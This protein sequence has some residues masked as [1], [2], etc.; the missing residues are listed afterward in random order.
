MS[1]RV[2]LAVASSA[3][4][5]AFP[6]TGT[7]ATREGLVAFEANWSIHLV[8]PD[9]SGLRVLAEK[10]EPSPGEGDGYLFYPSFTPDGS[11]VTYVNGPRV[12]HQD[13]LVRRVAGGGAKL[14]GVD[15]YLLGSPLSFSPDGRFA[16][17]SRLGQRTGEFAVFISAT[18]GGKERQLTGFPAPQR[19]TKDTRP[20][21]SPDGRSIVFSRLQEGRAS[22][23]VVRASGGLAHRLARGAE[24]D[25]APDGQRIAFVRPDGV[26]VS[27]P[28]GTGVRRI[29]AAV[30]PGSPDFAPDG[31]RLAYTAGGS[32]WVVSSSG[33]VPF[34]IAD[35]VTG[36]LDW[37]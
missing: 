15:G 36:D 23:M 18:R 20:D 26:Y 3:V 31:S 10:G 14:F 33:G 13:V 8:E 28:D 12:T 22:L 4:V 1:A 5:A 34:K 7:T 21:W 9:G 25:W 30:R 17:V 11:R 19:L 29:V 32:V 24:P 35:G 37:G 27:R 6:G 2:A 16:A